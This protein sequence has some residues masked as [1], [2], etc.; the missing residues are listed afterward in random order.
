MAVNRLLES[1]VTRRQR[2]AG[3]FWTLAWLLPAAALLA[4]IVFW[5]TGGFRPAPT[6]P[7]VQRE[8]TIP[9]AEFLPISV[10]N[11]VYT[12]RP[13]ALMD[14]QVVF[15]GGRD[16]DARP[17]LVSLDLTTGE[18]VWQG[19]GE[20]WGTLAD[21][22]GRVYVEDTAGWGS[23]VIAYEGTTGVE[24]WQRRFT[25][26]VGS[27]RVSGNGVIV[28]TYLPVH[29]SFRPYFTSFHLLDPETGDRLAHK[30]VNAAQIFMIED[31]ERSYE[32]Q[33]GSIRA[34]GTDSWETP[35]PG[36]PHDPDTL[37][38]Y[39]P[40]LTD[41]LI[42][43]KT[44]SD[45]LGHVYA[46]NKLDGSIRWQLNEQVVGNVATDYGVVYLLL[47]DG[48]LMGIEASSGRPVGVHYFTPSLQV[49][50][51]FPFYLDTYQD[52]V[53]VYLGDSRQLFVFRFAPPA[54]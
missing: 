34:I 17:T 13:V 26:R 22:S 32:A 20:A 53:G 5:L 54:S 40:L 15:V 19:E 23:R 45:L 33:A 14:G 41:D 46:L 43:V 42:L 4:V 38:R 9:S 28:K 6:T 27:L 12:E 18:Q 25:G 11:A 3:C 48:R 1:S 31:K 44:G 8:A 7:T 29:T 50:E 30:R 47:Q 39:A 37:Y 24:R 10:F 51:S 36:E 16:P 2:P 49:E 52:L 35:L 21:G